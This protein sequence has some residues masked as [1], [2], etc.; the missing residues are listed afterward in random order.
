MALLLV[1]RAGSCAK[2]DVFSYRRLPSPLFLTAHFAHKDAKPRH[3][4]NP[5]IHVNGLF[6]KNPANI[7]IP[8]LHATAITPLWSIFLLKYRITLNIFSCTGNSH[9]WDRQGCQRRA[10]EKPF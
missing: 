8:I 10:G 5:S 4:P 3:S 1:H 7:N 2:S 6:P 9:R